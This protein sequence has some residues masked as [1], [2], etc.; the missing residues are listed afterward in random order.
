MTE[1]FQ[2]AFIGN[3]KVRNRFVRSSTWD[4]LARE[5]GEVT[6]P[7]IDLYR[8]LANGVVGLILS[9]YAFIDKR[10]KA[11]PRM[12]GAD[13]D[14]L[15]PGLKQ[16]ANAVHE[17][18]GKVVLQIAHGGAQIMFDTGLTL[19][20]PSAVADRLTGKMPV[21]MTTGDIERVVAEFADAA[22]RAR[23]AGFDGVQMHGAHGYL[24]A[25]FLSP[26]TNVRSDDYG[27][28]IENRAKIV[29]ETYEAIRDA[30]GNDFPV[31][32]KINSSD[33]DNVGLAPEDSLWVCRKLSEMGID[34]IELSGGG[35]AAEELSPARTKIDAPGK[36][37]YFREYAKQ[38][39]PHLDC[40]L[41]LVGGLRS[42]EVA[43][44]IYR[45]G[46][47]QFFS[48]SRPFISEPDLI[49]RWQSGDTK[50]ARCVSC[51]KCFVPPARQKG[52]Y[53]VAFKNKAES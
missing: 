12:L 24:L 26:Y 16:L 9:G 38:F 22:R 3:M 31:M 40:P 15:I 1:L 18:D 29:F 11:S 25:Q 44:E 7:M 52:F 48:L 46:S 27:G 5:N 45:E 6:E 53:C 8:S 21:E 43:E 50:R 42:L 51:N 39:T 47:A 2:G 4:G 28:P 13:D 19:E 49:N 41:I 34:A 33:F 17:A 14:A 23:E 37:A 32:I 10:G 36:E 30:V 35:P 20:A